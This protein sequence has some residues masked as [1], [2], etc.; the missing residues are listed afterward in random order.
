MQNYEIRNRFREKQYALYKARVTCDQ[1]WRQRT[2]QRGIIAIT[3]LVS[4]TIMGDLNEVR[5][6][7]YMYMHGCIK[8]PMHIVEICRP[9]RGI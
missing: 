2:P 6:Y 8:A 5:I 4:G 9:D 7:V 1:L 3:V